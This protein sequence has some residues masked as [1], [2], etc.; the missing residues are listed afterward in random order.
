VSHFCEYDAHTDG[1]LGIEPCGEPAVAKWRGKWYCEDHLES[2]E[3][4]AE[5]IEGLKEVGTEVESPKAA[6]SR[7]RTS[8]TLPV[9]MSAISSSIA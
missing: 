1:R 4:H 9:R 2:M 3:A 7:P 5:L 6:G 8:G